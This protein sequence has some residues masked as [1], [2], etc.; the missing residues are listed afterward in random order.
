MKYPATLGENGPGGYGTQWTCITATNFSIVA[1]VY[2][3]PVK[4]KPAVVHEKKYPVGPEGTVPL[5][6]A[7]ARFGCPYSTLYNAQLAGKFRTVMQKGCIFAFE[8]DVE[9]FVKYAWRGRK[10]A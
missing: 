7:S 9:T 2:D 10:S 1:P 3:K 6:L 8:E 4:E 5:K